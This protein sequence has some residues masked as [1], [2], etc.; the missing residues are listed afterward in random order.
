MIKNIKMIG[1]MVAIEVPQETKEVPEV[2][3]YGKVIPDKFKTEYI[4]PTT[5]YIVHLGD[6]L[7]NS[8]LKFM[9]GSKV[10]LPSGNMFALP[11]PQVVDGTVTEKKGKSYIMTHY[12]N[13]IVVYS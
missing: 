4:I 13:I 11:D 3:P 12:K 8:E 7:H 5:G 1:D 9:E 6:A 2:D 10:L